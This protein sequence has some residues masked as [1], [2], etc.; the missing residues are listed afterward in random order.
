MALAKRRRTLSSGTTALPS[1]IDSL[2]VDAKESLVGVEQ[3]VNATE[4]GNSGVALDIKAELQQRLGSIRAFL[5]K[6]DGLL[7]NEK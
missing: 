5:G 2:L 6:I 7:S 4:K 3:W 1:N